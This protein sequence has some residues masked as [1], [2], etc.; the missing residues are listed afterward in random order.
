[1]TTEK[2][3]S[4]IPAQNLRIVQQP[5]STRVAAT[6]YNPDGLDYVAIRQSYIDTVTQSRAFKSL[7]PFATLLLWLLI[8]NGLR[9]SEIT[10]TR[11]CRVLDDKLL[12]IWQHKTSSFRTA[13]H[14]AVELGISM[15]EL[16]IQLRTNVEHRFAVYRLL[17]DCGCVYHAPTRKRD[18]VTHLF[19]R[20]LA[21]SLWQTTQSLPTV[22]TALGHRSLSSTINYL[23]EALRLAPRTPRKARMSHDREVKNYLTNNKTHNLWQKAAAF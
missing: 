13:S 9:V 11:R 6:L 2:Y 22:Q 17:L 21:L 12:L 1:M 3:V 19:R 16:Q 4:N 5:G 18:C 8:D 14:R 23:D 7:T 15:E 10:D 20:L